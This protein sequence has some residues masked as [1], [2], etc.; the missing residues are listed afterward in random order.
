MLYLIV[1]NYLHLLQK[2]TLSFNQILN[3]NSNIYNTKSHSFYVDK[4]NQ[5]I[6]SNLNINS[7]YN[8]NVDYISGVPVFTDI[9]FNVNFITHNLTN[10]F[11][12]YDKKLFD[13]L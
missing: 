9:K 8:H 3:Y 6:I 13:C 2:N 12:R 4:V 11:Y 1:I 7:I 10:N 5:P